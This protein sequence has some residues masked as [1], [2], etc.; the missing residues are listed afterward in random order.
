MGEK[1]ITKRE[2]NAAYKKHLPNRWIRFAFKYFSKET[3]MENMSLRN[4]LNF[5]LFGLFLLGFFATV[6]E[7]FL[8]FISVVTITYSLILT[9]LVLYLSS[10]TILNNVRI[11]KIINILGISK[12]EYNGLVRKYYN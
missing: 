8:A 11:K 10:A 4:Y 6:F 3:E 12:T 2:F 5:I 9:A 1:G 7:I